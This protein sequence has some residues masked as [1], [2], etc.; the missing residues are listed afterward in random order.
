LE[1]SGHE[2]NCEIDYNKKECQVNMALKIIGGG[3]GG[4]SGGGGPTK[5]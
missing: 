1:H 2:R 4:G 3:G 5:A